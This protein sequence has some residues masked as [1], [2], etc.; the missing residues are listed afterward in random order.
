MPR[1]AANLT[2]LWTDRPFVSRFDAAAR[3]G[4]AAVEYMFPYAEDLKAVAAE[5]RR[6]KLRQT[7]FNLPAGDWAAGERGIAVDPGRRDEFRD[8]VRQ[9]IDVARLLKCPRVNC[10]VGKQ[11][12]DV[13]LKD[14]WA[15][16][17][18]NI[19]M[20]A[21]AFEQVGLVLLVEPINTFDMPGFFLRTPSEA[22]ELQDKVGAANLKVQ[23][24][25]YHAQRMEGNLTQTITRNI[26]RI[27][28]IQIADA[29]DRNQPGTGEI[30]FSYLLRAIDRT[31][32]AG[33]IG[34]EYRPTG[35]TDE[36]FNWIEEMGFSRG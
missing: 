26:G 1:F 13:P 11:L 21:A 16:L 23:Y 28:H 34:L 33:D 12:E 18:D 27:G 9:G 14:Q 10:L 4:F 3:A 31:D 32:Y 8:G 29:P 19:K 35:A 17:V 6:L 25:V 2:F 20:A 30:N 15:C 24:D 5:L 36:S 7:L 22:F